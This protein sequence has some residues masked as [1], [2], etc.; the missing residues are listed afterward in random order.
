MYVYSSTL[1]HA[2][3][4]SQVY[5]QILYQ[6]SIENLRK[7]DQARLGSSERRGSVGGSR[8]ATA[9]ASSKKKSTKVCLC[10]LVYVFVY[11]YRCVCVHETK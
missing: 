1:S 5:F 4:V 8:R 7:L 11:V 2:H 6:Y 10:L 9:R 3:T